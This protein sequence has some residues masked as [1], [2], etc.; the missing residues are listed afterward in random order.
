MFTK[1][2]FIIDGH[3]YGVVA[4]SPKSNTI[5]KEG[6]HVMTVNNGIEDIK[7]EH[8]INPRHFFIDVYKAAV[9]L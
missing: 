9:L 1:V 6:I 2:K 4:R 8:G 5:P 7:K 3:E